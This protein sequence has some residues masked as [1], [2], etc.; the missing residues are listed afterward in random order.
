[1][2]TSYRS[3]PSVEKLLSDERIKDLVTTFSHQPVVEVLRGYLQEVRQGIAQG[4][5][6]CKFSDKRQILL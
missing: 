1:M 5:H 3:I 2:A 6:P 4:N